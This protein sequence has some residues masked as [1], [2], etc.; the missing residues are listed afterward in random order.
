MHKSDLMLRPCPM[1]AAGL[2]HAAVPM[3]TPA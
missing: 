3:H 2:M 1:R